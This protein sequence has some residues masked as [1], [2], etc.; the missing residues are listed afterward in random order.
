MNLAGYSAGEWLLLI[1]HELL[2]FAGLFFLFG[3]IDELFVD[4]LWLW[5]KLRGKLPARRQP[6]DELSATLTGPVA[7]MV[8]AW[9][10][11]AVIA[12]MIEHT[13]AV[14]PHRSLTLFVGCYHNDPA[15]LS[16]VASAAPRD[17]RLRLVIHETPGPTTKADCLNRIY[18]AL[19]D[20]E[21]RQGEEFRMVILHDAEDMVDPAAL[22]I[23]DREMGKADFIQLPVLPLVVKDSRWIAGHYCEEFAEAHGK[24]MVV[25][26]A[27]GAGLPSAGVGC[28]IRRSQLARLAEQ[29]GSEVPFSPDSLTEDYE[30]GLSIAAMGGRTR[31]LRLRTED[32]RLIA[33]RA[34]FPADIAQAVRQ[35]TRWLHG[36]AFQGWER[37]GWSWS[38]GESWMRLRDRRG[39]MTA[40]VLAIAYLL[41][42][43]AGGSLAASL[44]GWVPVPQLSPFLSALLWANLLSL[45][46]RALFRFGFTAREYGFGEGLRALLRIPVCNIIAIMAGRRAFAAYVRTLGGAAPTWDK[47]HHPYHPAGKAGSKSESHQE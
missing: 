43:V 11:E 7:V 30:L 20:E 23:F 42:L 6:I 12:A 18:R 39:P 40:L 3:A 19:E 5:L 36:I 38:P 34:Y 16:A 17:P 13:L 47:T 21:R 44:L 31:F 1:Q 22:S 33:T 28:A 45:L 24:G 26:D 27:I 2:L 29:R 4:L 37:L 41:V 25:R 9:R 46:W 32:G 8:P 15:S 14:W 10:E 35:K